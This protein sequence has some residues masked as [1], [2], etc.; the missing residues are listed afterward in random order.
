MANTHDVACTVPKIRLSELENYLITHDAAG[1]VVMLHGAAGIGKSAV[2]RA[3]AD[4]FYPLRSPENIKKLNRMKGSIGEF[5]VTQQM[6]TDFEKSLLDQDTNFVDV[7]LSYYEPTDLS[8]IPIP[9][10]MYYNSNGRVVFEKDIT[11]DM[12]VTSRQVVVWATP[13]IFSLPKDWKGVIL[14]DELPSTNPSTQAACYQLMLDSKIGDWELSPGAFK[15]AAGNRAED[16]GA[17]H[18][19]IATPLKDRMSHY[20]I[21]VDS[22]GFIDYAIRAGVDSEVISFIRHAPTRLHTLDPETESPVGGASPRSW[23]QSSDNIKQIR[24]RHEIHPTKIS[25]ENYDFMRNV[26]ASR[27]GMEI[28]G[29][30][31][32]YRKNFGVFPTPVE[33]L[34]DEYD[35]ELLLATRIT[36]D[37]IFFISNN[38]NSTMYELFKLYEDGG[39]KRENWIHC[40]NKYLEFVDGV[41]GD[42]E[43]EQCL[44][45]ISG[46]V[47]AKSGLGV[48]IRG[49]D[50]PQLNEVLRKYSGVMKAAREMR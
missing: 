12:E 29:E 14:F 36:S 20:E 19:G 15:M 8:G 45:T 39:L 40:C 10:T 1:D 27:V 7:R 28:A 48:V 44:A 47:N 50:V 34:A 13:A 41:I 6:V 3:Y 18:Y 49:S 24:S 31:M 37:M 23:V 38:L 42:K 22:A 26:I 21:L 16:G 25:D 32:A 4:K 9:I 46:L 33:I 5:G 2:A 30:F 35:R 17:M 43:P 11:P